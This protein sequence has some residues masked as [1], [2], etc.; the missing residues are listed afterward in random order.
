MTH[1]LPHDIP[2]ITR[3]VPVRFATGSKPW[4]LPLPPQEPQSKPD[5]E[6]LGPEDMKSS[7]RR[8]PSS[9]SYFRI[10][11]GLRWAIHTQKVKNPK[12]S[13]S[14]P[15]DLHTQPQTWTRTKDIMALQLYVFEFV[16]HQEQLSR[17]KPWFV[18]VRTTISD[19]LHFSLLTLPM[20]PSSHAW[21]SYG[22]DCCPFWG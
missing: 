9:G 6:K 15:K 13:R 20:L 14:L 1:L 2:S 12:W 7:D 16:S 18:H 5:G 10:F 3:K 22:P 4:N 19:A 17:L 11:S 21:I 8:Y